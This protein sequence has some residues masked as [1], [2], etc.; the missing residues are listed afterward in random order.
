M[1]QETKLGTQNGAR[2]KAARKTVRE[3]KLVRKTVRENKAARKTMQENGAACKTVQRNKAARKT[4]QETKLASK[5]VRENKAELKTIVQ[6]LGKP[7]QEI[8]RFNESAAEEAGISPDDVRDLDEWLDI[9]S[10]HSGLMQRPIVLNDGKVRI[11]RPQEAV[12]EII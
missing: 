3:T 2:N 4:V 5:T 10:Q 6:R 8:I 12:L 11:G 1:V 7:P 9:L